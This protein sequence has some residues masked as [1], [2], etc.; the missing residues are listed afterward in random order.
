MGIPSLTHGP[1]RG[2][3]GAAL[4]LQP[5]RSAQQPLMSNCLPMCRRHWDSGAQCET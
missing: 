5:L 1:D 4:Q 3:W 2:H